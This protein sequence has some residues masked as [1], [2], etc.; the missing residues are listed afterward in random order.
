MARL[1]KLPHISDLCHIEM[2][3]RCAKKIISHLQRKQ[4]HHFAEIKATNINEDQNSLLVQCTND[5]VGDHESRRRVSQIN[6]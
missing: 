1:T 3:A 5:F 4:M 2:I 6:K